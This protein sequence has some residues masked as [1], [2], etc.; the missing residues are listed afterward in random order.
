M[1]DSWLRRVPHGEGCDA[2]FDWLVHTGSLT[3][4]L[5]AARPD[6]RVR[7]L[8]QRLARPYEDERSPLRLRRGELAWVRD[9]L[10][11]AGDTPLVF[12]HSVLPRRNV[13]GAWH[14]FAG[15]GARPL[16]EILFTDPAVARAPL[17][18]LGVDRR[19]PLHG[20]VAAALGPT[21]PR[22]WA[23]RSLFRRGGRAILVTEIFLP[24]ILKLAE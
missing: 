21:A 10:L 18:Y 5:R 9:V 12:A 13:R 19:H 11:L 22:L 8:R 14:L 4:R 24:A 7:V 16:G 3:A 23:R 6:F 15:L 20:A 2:Y 17:R 1:K